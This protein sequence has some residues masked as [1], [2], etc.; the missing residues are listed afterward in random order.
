MSQFQQPQDNRY[1]RPGVLDLGTGRQFE[2]LSVSNQ[3]AGQI[4]TGS[5]GGGVVHGHTRTGTGLSGIDPLAQILGAAAGGINAFLAADETIMKA[6]DAQGHLELDEF[7]REKEEALAA[8]GAD[9]R[10]IASDYREKLNSYRKDR[11]KLPARGTAGKRFDQMRKG[12]IADDENFDYKASRAKLDQDIANAA[13][14]APTIKGLIEDWRNDMEPY[15]LER[16]IDDTRAQYNNVQ[17]RIANDETQRAIQ[18]ANNRFQQRLKTDGFIVD[19]D[20]PN[21]QRITEI[22]PNKILEMAQ[23]RG[24]SVTDDDALE[25]LTAAFLYYHEE[26]FVGLTPQQQK[27]LMDGWSTQ[28]MRQAGAFL[29]SARSTIDGWEKDAEVAA[30]ADNWTSFLR[31]E[32]PIYSAGEDPYL[33]A[34]R[35]GYSDLASAVGGEARRQDALA[36]FGRRFNAAV[37]QRGSRLRNASVEDVSQAAT[38]LLIQDSIDASKQASNEGDHATSIDILLGARLAVPET[39]EEARMAGWLGV[40]TEDRKIE[41]TE[42]QW[43]VRRD[44][45]LS[46]IT[47]AQLEAS[48][49]A[50]TAAVSSNKFNPTGLDNLMSQLWLLAGPEDTRGY[51]FEK[52]GRV[53]P[54]EEHIAPLVY[55]DSATPF[56]NIFNDIANAVNDYHGTGSKGSVDKEG[57]WL[58][59]MAAGSS[60]S[61]ARQTAE[62]DTN[63]SEDNIRQR[64]GGPLPAAI[65]DLV[66]WND[67]YT[68]IAEQG[69]NLSPELA[70]VSRYVMDMGEEGR[71]F[72]KDPASKG[73]LFGMIAKGYAENIGSKLQGAPDQHLRVV[74]PDETTNWTGSIFAELPK[75]VPPSNSH[76]IL[77]VSALWDSLYVE[78]KPNLTRELR[79]EAFGK[80]NYD[81]A[82][83]TAGLVRKE[84]GRW[85]PE[86]HTYKT[87]EGQPFDGLVFDTPRTVER[88]AR[89]QERMIEAL[90]NSGTTTPEAFVDAVVS[91]LLAPDTILGDSSG[92]DPYSMARLGSTMDTWGED[93][94][95]SIHESVG[96]HGDKDDFQLSFTA[97]QYAD[98]VSSVQMDLLSAIDA[99]QVDP[100]KPKSVAAYVATAASEHIKNSY[101]GSTVVGGQLVPDPDGTLRAI[102][103]HESS[104]LPEDLFGSIAGLHFEDMAKAAGR[105]NL[106]QGSRPKIFGELFYETV[107]LPGEQFSPFDLVDRALEII[108][109]P[110]DYGAVETLKVGDLM[111]A[112]FSLQRGDDKNTPFSAAM[113]EGAQIDVRGNEAT[114]A[115]PKFTVNGRTMTGISFKSPKHVTG[116]TFSWP[117][118][119]FDLRDLPDTATIGPYSK[120]D[121]IAIQE[122]VGNRNRN[123]SIEERAEGAFLT[124]EEAKAQ[125]LLELLERNG[126][127][128]M[129]V[130]L[131][132]D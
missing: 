32:S 105:T 109:K 27:I 68:Y 110:K 57:V 91:G 53:L 18:D 126:G 101:G 66:D 40:V 79:E 92:T 39:L 3:G 83:L 59:S 44:E 121:A 4:A 65:N 6:R 97:K 87:A 107:D 55:E 30:T 50:F 99:G 73:V 80:D 89:G 45:L 130:T 17:A 38:S 60:A 23:Q 128:Y 9:P 47:A 93:F 22:N 21:G 70:L 98:V 86:L 29:D 12:A 48:E 75:G 118:R 34:S 120:A 74:I 115:L 117:E 13:G 96:Y 119:R 20:G 85:D 72:K 124:R 112:H 15:N 103:D 24:F 42:D 125:G 54:G 7:E 63:P 95:D 108:E 36:S 81:A 8:D 71:P 122:A 25:Q 78:G 1:V 52:L 76:D 94:I 28:F 67:V 62:L 102:A 114:F 16:A 77:G 2:R 10:K 33:P 131:K 37:E 82:S 113:L 132:E 43:E 31:D 111:R 11:G 116:R 35:Y 100:T 106:S 104:N 19:V 90:R 64:L 127:S 26:D 69:E 58:A 129:G 14:H 56:Q 49:D 51:D 46:Q 5:R 88:M 123:L 41:M 84:G 61:K